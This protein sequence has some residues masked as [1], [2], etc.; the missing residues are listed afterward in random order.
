[1]SQTQL[2]SPI[3]RRKVPNVVVCAADTARPTRQSLR[4]MAK[5]SKKSK[6]P[7]HTTA[8]ELHEAARLARRAG[9]VDESKALLERARVAERIEARG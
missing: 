2:Q 7:K 5:T 9:E 8:A 3:R 1:M 4:T 6:A